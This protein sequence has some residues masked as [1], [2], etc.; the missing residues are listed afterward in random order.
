M[1]PYCSTM[2]LMSS[3]RRV[4][5][6][7]AIMHTCFPFIRYP[8]STILPRGYTRSSRKSSASSRSKDFI[9]T[10]QGDGPAGARR[11]RLVTQ[12]DGPFKKSFLIA[13]RKIRYVIRR[14]VLFNAFRGQSVGIGKTVFSR[15]TAGPLVHELNKVL[16]GTGDSLGQGRWRHW[17]I[18]EGAQRAGRGPEISRRGADERSGLHLGRAGADRYDLISGSFSSTSRAVITLVV[19]AGGTRI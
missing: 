6:K 10:F 2:D 17:R 19:L 11:D 9:M 18:S 5:P 1:P 14:G 8:T 4:Q 16:L 13:S 7:T 15:P 3:Q 12:L